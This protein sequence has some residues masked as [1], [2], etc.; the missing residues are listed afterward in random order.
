MVTLKQTGL[1]TTC[2][3]F[4]IY[5]KKPSKVTIL[6]GVTYIFGFFIKFWLKWYTIQ[7]LTFLRH[8]SQISSASSW[9]TSDYQHLA[10]NIW[11]RQASVVSIGHE[12]FAHLPDDGQD[13]QSFLSVWT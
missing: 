7:A 9:T 8:K 2:R 4:Q 10:R 6:H 3:K 1:P 5:G 13:H 12:N 11:R